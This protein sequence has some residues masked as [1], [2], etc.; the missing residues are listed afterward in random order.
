TAA[1]GPGYRT[2]ARCLPSWRELNPRGC[3]SGDKVRRTASSGRRRRART[4][5]ALEILP[6]DLFLA[7][8]LFGEGFE[9]GAMLRQQS[10]CVRVG[11]VEHAP[12]LRF[13]GLCQAL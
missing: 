7:E 4:E 9:L 6:I 11:F 8:Q 10:G 2:I 5:Q 3:T 1:A 13:D 12:M